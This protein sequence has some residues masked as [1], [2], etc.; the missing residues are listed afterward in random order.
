MV[1]ANET[2]KSGRKLRRVPTEETVRNT[3]RDT[4]PGFNAEET[5]GFEA[6]AGGAPVPSIPWPPVADLGQGP[7]RG[8]RPQSIS[9]KLVLKAYHSKLVLKACH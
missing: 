5:D 2:P 8:P 6:V 9:L 1:D 4:F 7:G 3:F